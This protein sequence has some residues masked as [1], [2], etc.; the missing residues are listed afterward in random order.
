MSQFRNGWL[1]SVPIN[2]SCASAMTFLIP[3][4]RSEGNGEI[5]FLKV[6]AIYVGAAASFD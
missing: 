1:I 5:L 6:I 4:G 3:S 2:P